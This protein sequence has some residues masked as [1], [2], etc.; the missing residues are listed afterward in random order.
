ML[1]FL[2]RNGAKASKNIQ[3]SKS[4]TACKKTNVTKWPSNLQLI[5]TTWKGIMFCICWL[6]SI[7]AEWLWL[8]IFIMQI[9]YTNKYFF[10]LNS[11]WRMPALINPTAFP[12]CSFDNLAISCFPNV[13]IHTMYTLKTHG[14][15]IYIFCANAR[16]SR[17][18]LTVCICMPHWTV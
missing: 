5:R 13:W 8:V 11:V 17:V 1:I 15:Y 3:H 18:I 7:T 14:V 12:R 10:T 2:G 4:V 6:F 16:F 9:I